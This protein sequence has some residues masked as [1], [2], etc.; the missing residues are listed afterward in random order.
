MKTHF[1][2]PLCNRPVFR[3]KNPFPTVDVVIEYQGSTVLIERKNPPYGWA[4]PGGFIDYGESAE[5]AAV[6]EAHEETS[7]RVKIEG[8]L[9]V[10]SDP[11][12]DPRFHT[13][14]TVFYGT[15]SGEPRARDD[16]IR[17]GLF[18][19]G[20]LPDVIAFDHRSILMD[21]YRLSER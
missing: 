21:Y 5:A 18:D 19:R 3:Y 16:A 11:E 17:I 20:T 12:R 6:R 7:L 2:C 8:L 9:G 4:L 13:I 1:Y 10:Y 15:G 14:T